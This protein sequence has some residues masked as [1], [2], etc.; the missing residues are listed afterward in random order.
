MPNKL[1]AD[2]PVPAGMERKP[3]ETRRDFATRIFATMSPEQVLKAAISGAA[4]VDE[5]EAQNQ[6]QKKHLMI[7]DA[8]YRRL[9]DVITRAASGLNSGTTLSQRR[10][11]E[12]AEATRIFLNE[13]VAIGLISERE[14]AP[15]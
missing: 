11:A 6:L 4:F 2:S 7:L 9:F 13:I 8:E 1:K 15:R 14:R 10:R 3:G 5:Q 12:I